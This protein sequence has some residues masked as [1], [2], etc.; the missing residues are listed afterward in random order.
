MLIPKSCELEG[1]V[2]GKSSIE[3]LFTFLPTFFFPSIQLYLMGG[4]AFILGE[5]RAAQGCEINHHWPPPFDFSPCCSLPSIHR[6]SLFLQCC[7]FYI[8]IPVAVSLSLMRGNWDWARLS[9]SD[10]HKSE[11]YP[12]W[13][14]DADPSKRVG[15]INLSW[16]GGGGDAIADRVVTG[17]NVSIF[18]LLNWTSWNFGNYA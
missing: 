12:C 1:K 4:D 6:S 11:V 2:L 5:G 16:V 13:P 18:A 7:Y 8:W 10:E 14:I 9:G 15:F 17:L 3:L